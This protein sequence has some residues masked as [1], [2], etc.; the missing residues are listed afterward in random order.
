MVLE[1]LSL[2]EVWTFLR[3]AIANEAIN[4]DE[5]QAIKDATLIL[6]EWMDGIDGEELYHHLEEMVDV[7]H[8]KTRR[9]G[10]KL[11]AFSESEISFLVEEIIQFEE[12][13]QSQSSPRSKGGCKDIS[14]I[15]LLKSDTFVELLGKVLARKE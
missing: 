9:S 13:E 12:E 8:S 5:M 2:Y 1:V 15:S 7:I 3:T 11:N 6:L 4:S 14:H 10:V